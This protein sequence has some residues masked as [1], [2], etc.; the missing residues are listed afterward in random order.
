MNEEVL[1]KWERRRSEEGLGWGFVCL[2]SSC[3][4]LLVLLCFDL[5]FLNFLLWGH[6]RGEG[7]M[8]Y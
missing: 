7:N 3:F 6:C 4:C 1:E 2:F 8:G 5:I